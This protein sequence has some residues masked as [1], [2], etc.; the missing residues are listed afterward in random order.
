MARLAKPIVF[1]C[2]FFLFSCSFL[3]L[4]K[5]TN[6]LNDSASCFR[7]D[8]TR[9]ML[10]SSYPE[11]TASGVSE[12]PYVDLTFSEE[13]KG[14]EVLDNYSLSGAG[15]SAMS[16]SSV[17][18][19][20]KYTYRIYLNGAVNNNEIR[21]DFS[22]LSDYAGNTL[23]SQ[24][25]VE[26][27]GNTVMEVN[28]TAE[29]N[30]GGVSSNGAAGGYAGLR[31]RFSHNYRSDP[32]NNTSW[33]I[34][35][36]PGIVDCAAGTPWHNPGDG[37]G[38]N[39][40]HLNT[41][42]L[43]NTELVR[44]FV[45]A[46][47]TNPFNAIVIC[48]TNNTNPSAKATG[49]WY[50]RRNDTAP[51]MSYIPPET[52]FYN[53]PVSVQLTCSGYPARIAVTETSQQTVS[54]PDPSTP[55]FDANTGA[56]TAGTPFT[57]GNATVT[58]QNPANPTRTK[59]T[60]QCI[61]VAGNKS[62]LAGNSNIEYYVDS[63]IPAVNVTLDGTIRT[64][65]SATGYTSTTLKFRTDQAAGE[66]WII[67][68]GGT[69]CTLGGTIMYSG[70]VIAP[71]QEISQT[72]DVG[73][74][75]TTDF[76]VVGLYP[77]RI[78]VNRAANN[79]W[80]T[81]FL[82]ITRDDTAPT[83]SS[84]VTSGSYGA[85]QQVTLSCTDNADV[86]S[87]IKTAQLGK[88]GQPILV[89][90]PFAA[91]GSDSVTGPITLDDSST[92]IM[93]Y[94][95]R[96][97]AGNFSAIQQAQ[98]TIDATLPNITVVS[99]E[100]SAL[101]AAGGFATSQLVWRSTRGG[102]P[103]EIRRGVADCTGGPGLGNANNILTGTTPTDL[104]NI[105]V[106]L[107]AA[108]HFPGNGTYDLKICVFNYIDAPTYQPTT[109]NIV[110]DDSRPN[111]V[112][113]LTVTAATTTS[114][115]LSWTAPADVG[116]SGVGLYRIYQTVTQGN[117][118]SATEYT[119]ATN[120]VNVSGLT[121]GT[122]YY[123]VVRAVDNAGNVSLNNS[124]EVQ[125]RFTLSVTV[126]G[127]GA[128][129]NGP[130][131]VQLG[132]GE[133]MS[134]TANGTQTFSQAFLSGD[135]YTV[136]IVSQ[137]ATQNCA[138]AGNQYGTLTASVTLQLT[139][140]TGYVS[141]GGLIASRPAPLNYL[142]YRGNAQVIAGGATTGYNDGSGTA[143]LFDLPHGMTSVNGFLYVADR[144]N[145]RIRRIDTTVSPAATTTFAGE[146][147]AGTSDSTNPLTAR[148]N[149]PQAITTDGVNLYVV[150]APTGQPG[151]LRKIVIASGVVTTLA[152][153]GAQS[154]GTGCPGTAQTDC[155]DGTGAQVKFWG[156]NGI[157]YHNGYLY[158][159]EYGNNRVR[160]MNLATG[161]VDTIAGDGQNSS[162]ADNVDGSA[163]SF[164]GP[165]GAAVVGNQLYM[166]DFNGH[167]IRAVSLTAPFTVTAVAGTINIAGHADG[168]LASAR[169]HNPNHLTTDGYNL[170]VTEYGGDGLTGRRLRRIDL[171]K[172]RVSTIAGNSQLTESAGIG[173]AAAF[174]GPVGIAS[175]GR[176]LFVAAYDSGRIFRVTDSGLVGYWP[177]NGSST[178]YA[179][180]VIDPESG[181]PQDSDI[182]PTLVPV[183]G[184]YGENNG[185]YAFDGNNDYIHA[186]GTNLP[187]GAASRTLCAWVRIDDTSNAGNDGIVT[188]GQR[189]ANTVFGLRM[190]NT[191]TVSSWSAVSDVSF[192]TPLTTTKWAHTCIAHSGTL[193]RVYQNGHLTNYGTANYNTATG[194]LCVGQRSRPDGS[195]LC[196][197]GTFFFKGAIA[198]VRVYNRPLNEGEIH[199]L[200]QDA[201]D[202]AQVGNSFNT[203]ATG[204]LVHY[205]FSNSIL[206]SGPIGAS[207]SQ[208]GAPTAITGKDGDAGGGKNFSSSYHF[209][210]SD[211]GLPKS[212]APRTLCTWLKPARYPANTT[213]S[214]LFH[215]G[216]N[217][218]NQKS[219][220]HLYTD[221]A[222][223]KQIVFLGKNNDHAVNYAL[224]LNAWSHLCGT[225]D[226]TNAQMY[227]NGAAVGGAA[228][229]S[230]W[231]TGAGPVGI[232]RDLD[233]APEYF[234]GTLDDI[235]IY[236]NALS[237]MQIRQLAAQVPAG[238]LTHYDFTGDRND[239]SGWN[240]ALSVD[241][242]S[243]TLA[244]DRFLRVD[245]AAR[246][247]GSSR[248][249]TA[250]PV[251]AGFSKVA[252]TAWVRPTSFAGPTI[253]YIAVNGTG[254]DGYGILVNHGHGVCPNNS[255]TLMGILGGAGY[256]CST[257]SIPL[258]VWSHVAL[259]ENGAGA[260][261]TLYMNGVAVA[262]SSLT[263][264]T[265]SAGSYIGSDAASGF[266]SADVDDV[267]FYNRALSTSELLTLAG[268]H[269]MQVSGGT[270][271]FHANAESLSNLTNGTA[272]S[273]WNDI[274]Q[275]GIVMG[276]ST[277]ALQPLYAATGINGR[278]AVD[279]NSRFFTFPCNAVL[280][281][282]ANTIMGV[283][284]Q[285]SASGAFQTVL[286]HGNKLLYFNGGNNQFNL[287]HTGSGA[288][289]FVVVYSQFNF[290]TFGGSGS[291][292]IFATEHNGSSGTVY[293][294]GASAAG[295]SNSLG[296]YS[297]SCTGTA[298]V[299][300][301]PWGP[302][303][304]NG[305][306]GEIIYFDQ[307]LTANSVYGAPYTERE[308]VQCYLSSK[309]SIALASGVVCP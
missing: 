244:P 228:N 58:A 127:Y 120:S 33:F 226:G 197:G 259:V 253:Q 185:A 124:N 201:G 154:G 167:R 19:T 20:G 105:S 276:Q 199:E 152:G 42:D 258:N 57:G 149:G 22:K 208:G 236:N 234:D 264:A 146:G 84:S 134:F 274:S 158:I 282:S 59:F 11:V 80:G 287:Y 180:D 21:I 131:R 200:S 77:I 254:G 108:T 246:L 269:P 35:I 174:S 101:S 141:G 204:L 122:T 289:D 75:A 121:T 73:A 91:D 114:V 136:P 271:R 266:I 52:D 304:F 247:D 239:A 240:N 12:L 130:F 166:A 222:G 61:D 64:F 128:S 78:C 103:Y 66:Q 284:N 89:N 301:V 9:P 267:R 41:S 270:M 281:S 14:G 183:A 30:R 177:L 126:S 203:G 215:Y 81:A 151:Y 192:G 273:E 291:N 260:T 102:L 125:S 245:Q 109:L 189:G 220:L 186:P 23:A 133:I 188:Y 135:N 292:M 144:G 250:A 242:G 88:V 286:E 256:I 227:V 118:T 299:G 241:A 87:H 224:P 205:E 4:D 265:P 140:V 307:A 54:P 194:H 111:D 116:A 70:T 10:L 214:G 196:D 230:A 251:L 193:T 55:A 237:A 168:P 216:A 148:F 56:V 202:T 72:I 112:T 184:R 275:T 31:I 187:L 198:D 261:W 32:T 191:S 164:K 225:F 139:C 179:S 145:N 223:N 233:G 309:Y 96:D 110:R 5:N 217:A 142:L 210:L 74:N 182:I 129:L 172:G 279:F 71:N 277:P 280:N 69:S 45:T 83:I 263:P 85:V 93:R 104:S 155:V 18:K 218:T 283:F 123:F 170:F 195:S 171:R 62:D 95:C 229:F 278:P 28:V 79:T 206:P 213:Y 16:L 235:R 34:R 99:N 296:P 63:N 143:A 175:D 255:D 295:G 132:A 98:Y 40:P 60:W 138:F 46:D 3:K 37:V 248:L 252:I 221:G 67:K 173:A 1:V 97:K 178:D 165:T 113:G 288:D 219:G 231:N 308:V 76:N 53:S 209:F 36:T 207:L 82:Q 290:L 305:L 249:A 272:I 47:F 160:R 190:Q 161:V 285:P 65:V 106:T 268:Y 212:A 13:M 6:C 297:Y 2:A 162:G 48:M 38:S 86:I 25:F 8:V 238:L 302:N 107:N 306:I 159:T 157:I 147:G 24:P 39:L 90:P 92:T 50:V 51:V 43:A 100:R 211:L 169:F 163:T 262:T 181:T 7:S 294:N 156:P 94:Q 119:S 176:R 26:Y 243:P 150:E 257:V 17:T 293:K 44:D 29:H 303:Y 153:G 137:P 15:A 232:G 49:V 27:E 117:Y 300:Q 115:A 68:K 298:T